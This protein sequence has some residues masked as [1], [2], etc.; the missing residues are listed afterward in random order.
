MYWIT[1][2]SPGDV[3]RHEKLWQCPSF[4]CKNWR[5]DKRFRYSKTLWLFYVSC[6]RCSQLAEPATV[7]NLWFFSSSCFRSWKDPLQLWLPAMLLYFQE[8]VCSPDKRDRRNWLQPFPY[9]FLPWTLTWCLELQQ[10]SCCTMRE[11]PRWSQSSWLCIIHPATAATYF[12][13]PCFGRKCL[14]TYLLI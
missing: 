13:I 2:K 14:F 1:I 3:Y 11:R 9:F 7:P 10:P 8:Y 12:Q 5:K 6:G 4:R